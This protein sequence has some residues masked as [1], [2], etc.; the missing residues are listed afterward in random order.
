MNSSKAYELEH[1]TDIRPAHHTIKSKY[2]WLLDYE[3]GRVYKYNISAIC[4]EENGYNPDS[5]ACE[6]FLHGARPDY[7]IKNCEWMVTSEEEIIKL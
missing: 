1:G 6:A 2:I 7:G 4:N 5:E 3:V